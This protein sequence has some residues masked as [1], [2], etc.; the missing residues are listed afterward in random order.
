[1]TLARTTIETPLG[2]M[3]ALASDRGLVALEFD[4]ESRHVRLE[5]RLRKFLPGHAVDDRLHADALDRT[6]A[7]L[8]RYFHGDDADLDALTLDQYG[9]PFE[10]K[11]WRALLAI[12]PGQTETY[13]GIAATIGA[14]GAARAVG[15]ANGANPIAIVVPCHRVIGSNGALT[16]YGGGL[17]RKRW[18]LDHERRWTPDRL[19]L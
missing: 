2:P 7:W 16:G 14:P 17:D 11:V 13:G 4:A 19:P 18:L 1:M 8:D 5:R 12:P 15:L 6:R 9:E 3:L 10:L